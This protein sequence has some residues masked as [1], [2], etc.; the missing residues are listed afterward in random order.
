MAKSLRDRLRETTDDYNRLR[1]MF[2]AIVFRD[3]PFTLTQPDIDAAADLVLAS[4][5]NEAGTEVTVSVTAS[6]GNPAGTVQ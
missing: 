4:T 1:A 6:G 3:G 2:M 5:P